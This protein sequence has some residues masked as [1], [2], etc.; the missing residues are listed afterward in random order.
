MADV[1]DSPGQV[2]GTM[3]SPDPMP[4]PAPMGAG[5]GGGGDPRTAVL[6]VRQEVGKVVVGQEGTLSGLVAALLANG[7]VLLEGVPGVAKTLIVK[8]LAA[9]L[10]LDFK[11]V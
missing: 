6:A 8:A 5:G 9:S 7:H 4:A 3:P 10:S 11:R 2:P 1:P